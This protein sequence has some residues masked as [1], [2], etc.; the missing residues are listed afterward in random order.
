MGLWYAAR[1]PYSMAV[2]QTGARVIYNL[3]EGAPP[4][5]ILLKVEDG[6]F[7]LNTM[8]QTERGLRYKPLAVNMVHWN[9]ILFLALVLVTP[10]RIVVRRWFL[11]LAGAAAL[12]AS[13]VT[14]FVI[15]I[16][17]HLGQIYIVEGG[18]LD[19]V[20]SWAPFMSKVAGFYGTIFNPIVPFLF[21]LP[22][23]IFRPRAR[24]MKEGSA[25]IA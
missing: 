5:E 15:S 22:V 18:S 9:A 10:L 14:F 4:P 7:L 21:F 16:Y 12:F 25:P 19:E 13:Q 2:S 23:F 11:V 24:L 1:D 17:Y 6:T 8:V 20:W 3:L